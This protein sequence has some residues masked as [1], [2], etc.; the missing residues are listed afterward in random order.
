M[1]RA[2]TVAF[3]LLVGTFRLFDATPALAQ[4]ASDGPQ[5]QPA[6]EEEVGE[7][8]VLGS[9]IPRVQKEGP[10][11]VTVI[12][13]D[14]IKANGLVSVPDVL[15]S[16]SQNTGATQSQQDY[17]GSDFTPG[18][19]QVDLRGLGPGH[20]LVLVNGRRIADFPLPLNAQS[21]FTDISNIPLGMIESV[22][23]LSAG[24]SAIYG[25][26]AVAGVINFN[27]KKKVEGTTIDYRY[28]FTEHGG[29]GSQRLMMSSG[30]SRG[31][32]DAVFGIEL[33]DKKPLWGYQRS[34]QDSAKD[35]PSLASPADAVARRAYLIEDF[36]AVAYLDPGQE[37]CAALAAQNGG[38]T[39]WATR[40]QYGYY[41]DDLG[42]YLPG[43]Y[44]GS[45]ESYGYGTIESQRRAANL[46]ASLNYSL[47]D[48][49]HQ[50]FTDIQVGRGKV[51][52]FKDVQPWGYLNRNGL[53]DG[54]Y[55]D[56]G[57]G[58]IVDLQRQFSP[59]EMGPLTENMV[60]T[61]EH[62]LSITPGIKGTLGGD[63][64]YELAFNHSEYLTKVSWPRVVTDLAND[65]FMGP[66]LGTDPDSGYPIFEL[67]LDRFYT[68]LT[69][70]Q[71][72]AISA[73]IDAFP[74]SRNDNLS[75]TVS[76]PA[77]FELPAGPVG[78]AA[79]AEVGSQAYKLNPDP[80]ILENYYYYAWKSGDGHGKRDHWG[81]GAE[82]RIPIFSMLQLSTAGRYDNYKFKDSSDN[83]FT[84][85]A[86]LELRP[87]QTLL[88]RSSY[89][90]SFRA[91]DLHYVYSQPDYTHPSGIDYVTCLTEAPGSSASDCE[92]D[93][94]FGILRTRTGNP[95]LKSETSNSFGVGFVWSPIRN[96][97][98]SLDFWRITLKNEVRDQRVDDILRL[99]ANC[100]FGELD[101]NSAICQDAISRV[102]RYGAGPFE[103]RLLGV[104]VNPINISTSKTSGYDAAVHYS[105]ET[106]IGRLSAS[107]TFTYVKTF[108]VRQFPGDPLEDQLVLEANRSYYLPRSKATA[109]VGWSKGPFSANVHGRRIARIPNSD[110]DQWLKAF[111]LFNASGQ[112][113]FNDQMTLSIVVNNLFDKDPRRDPTASYPYYDYSWYDAV[114]RSFYLQA[115][116]RFGM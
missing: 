33:L 56:Q 24:A 85:N 77:L 105:L 63:W 95:S 29:G 54:A 34:I 4:N 80:L 108:D 94:E 9:R 20:T 68:P 32:F 65:Y 62:T 35:D 113:D 3:A 40:P 30:F 79:I 2:G 8:V 6:A 81:T 42:D 15:K 97:D 52:S 106:A 72:D 59:E 7:I 71:Y 57:F 23:V 86:G 67:D 82:L 116:Y 58:L 93:Y 31:N 48:G 102:Q 5:P 103:G 16:V 101:I 22:E 83:R 88:L 78:F 26:D 17:N 43:H 21:N 49:T 87:V 115:S 60:T 53:E 100:T 51:K 111:T 27:L 11:P 69:E 90:T 70:A 39:Y 89:G 92:D 41:D 109:N 61:R 46:Y 50:L 14:Q 36:D 107:G 28:G 76:K 104:S 12:T 55:F 18:A 19:E 112:Y 98:V 45:D 73:R 1:K 47:G 38:T 114:G 44:C 84:Y 13:A 96:F 110:Q 37:R 75:F 64:S 10:S 66:Q 74:R 25:S 91:P 99:E